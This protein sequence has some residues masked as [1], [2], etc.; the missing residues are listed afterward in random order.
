MH[1][2]RLRR[3]LRSVLKSPG[4]SLLAVVAL[5]LGIGQTTAMYS[6]VQGA[7]FSPLP[8]HEPQ[9]LM[10]LTSFNVGDGPSGSNN[11]F[12]VTAHD[13]D[14]WRNELTTFSGVGA[15]SNKEVNLNDEAGFPE[16]YEGGYLT[17]NIPD[18][19]GVPPVIGRSLTAEDDVPGAP[20]V[21]LLSHDLWRT[22]FESNP[23]IA[24]HPIRVDGEVATVIGVMPETFRVPVNEDLFMPMRID[25]SDLRRGEGRL[26]VIGRLADGIQRDE[27]QAE[28]ET[29]AARQAERWPDTNAGRA[30][31]VRDYRSSLNEESNRA[32]VGVMFAGVCLVLIVACANVASLLLVRSAARTK[33]LALR[34]ALGASRRRLVGVLVVEST[35]LALA[36]AILGLGVAQAGVS[37]MGNAFSWQNL[38][39]WV[40]FKIEPSAFLFC[41]LT[42]LVAGVLTG[43]LPALKASGAITFDVLKDESRGSTGLRIG[44]LSRLLV[45]TELALACSLLV[46]TALMVR[47]VL[48]LQNDDPGFDTESIFI[49][50]LLLPESSYPEDADVVAFYENLVDDLAGLPEVAAVSAM[51]RPPGD[52]MGRTHYQLEDGSYKNRSDIPRTAYGAV[53][54]EFFAAF[55][56]ERR[57][58]RLFDRHDRADSPYVVVVN[59][60]FAERAWPGE[61]PI[62]KRLRMG[63]DENG[64][65]PWRTVVGLVPDAGVS[66]IHPAIAQTTPAGFY[67]PH[68]QQPW[69]RM[70]LGV[71][72]HSDPAAF[73]ATLRQR[74][75]RVDPVLP[76]SGGVT[77]ERLIWENTFGTKVIAVSFSIFGTVA[78]LLAAVG[79]FGLT[80]FSVN[81]RTPEIGIRMALGASPGEVLAMILRQGVG[82]LALGITLGLGLAM[83]LASALRIA[84]H[85]VEPTDP[86]AFLS[87]VLVLGSATLLACLVPAWRASRVDPNVALHYE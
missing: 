71:K 34:T 49:A 10:D 73:F 74:V 13:F 67:V 43:L 20:L 1:L 6:I 12:A 62:G 51:S 8:F 40:V 47:T 25:W 15:M 64:D 27:A 31:L 66:F 79:I 37:L 17:W 87:T 33:E 19:L 58:G 80:M 36:G 18:I 53:S 57:E 11:L 41:A 81:Q 4:T 9:R 14:D 86:A 29:I 44:R 72:T 21:V 50:N 30:V 22:R 16:R 56:I 59:E 45:V 42:S 55:G 82:R 2:S 85:N 48:N 28:F 24:G 60:S 61:N 3:T 39:F 65:E 54:P 78:L 46:V 77:M 23:D 5:G 83:A 76:V 68:A 32:I 69:R 63:Q 52:I 26:S 35:L 38:P 75:Q 7:L 84:F 70:T